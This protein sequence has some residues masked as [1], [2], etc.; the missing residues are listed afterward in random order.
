MNRGYNQSRV[1]SQGFRS[2]PRQSYGTRTYSGSN[3]RSPSTGGGFSR[4]GGYSG[5]GF[6]RGG[7]RGGGRR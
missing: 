4:G 3:F 6:S 5:G 7:M 1:P 2:V